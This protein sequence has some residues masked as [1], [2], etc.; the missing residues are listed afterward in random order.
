MIGDEASAVFGKAAA[1][2]WNIGMTAMVLRSA[3]LGAA[4]M[5]AM[6]TVTAAEAGTGPAPAPRGMMALKHLEKGQWELRPRGA[7]RDAPPAHRLCLGDP[8][9]L[10]RIRQGGA[11]CDQFIV[12]DTAERA[13]VTYQCKA[14]GA[15]RTDLRVETP[16]LVQIYTQGIADGA[17][18]SEALEGRRTGPCH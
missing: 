15:G 8:A 6:V 16:R 7:R 10:L 11:G 3:G 12:T 18:F 9:R 14:N 5:M 2:G 4:M 13:V 1:M 17:P